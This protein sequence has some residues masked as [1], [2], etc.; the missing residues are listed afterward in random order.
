MLNK[1]FR[2]S[3]VEQCVLCPGCLKMCEG[4]PRTESE[5]A[6]EGTMLHDKVAKH[7]ISGLSSEQM[8]CVE[9]CFELMSRLAP[10]DVWQHEIK[11]NVVDDEKVE[12]LEGTADLIL[13]NETENDNFELISNGILIDLK[14]GRGAVTPASE[15]WQL[16]TYATMMFQK[17]PISTCR[18]II[19]QPRLGNAGFSETTY[20]REDLTDFP[21]LLKNI[22][23]ETQS[24][25]Q[26]H[27]GQKQCKFC[28]A[29]P[30][31]PEYAVWTKGIS[32][33]VAKIEHTHELSIEGL[34][35]ALVQTS[36]VKDFIK[37]LTAQ[38]ASIE[39]V[40]RERLIKNEVTPEQIG[41]QLKTRKG[42]RKCADAQGVFNLL[43]NVIPI[44]AFMSCV[45][46]SIPDLETLYAKEAKGKGLF[47]SQKEAVKALADTIAPFIN[48]K[49][50]GFMLKK[51]TD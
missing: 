43:H 15:N 46:I 42:A 9:R 40:A 32:S 38:V 48:Q 28:D 16:K 14:F 29:K 37:Q 13:I 7:D 10:D 8:I 3:K 6:K 22:Y 17:Y 31:C 50:D 35:D 2:P 23:A 36:Q 4:I 39:N 51:L 44:E 1:D 24:G 27:A 47:K 30:T 12:I 11:M 5:Y 41:Y 21:L 19:F 20:S 34:H 25:I 45:D 18:C 49:P 33:A 26:L